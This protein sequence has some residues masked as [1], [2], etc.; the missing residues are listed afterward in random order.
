MT[1]EQREKLGSAG[2]EHVLNNYSPEQYAEQWEELFDRVVEK[3]GS[4]DTRK[5]YKAWELIEV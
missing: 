1:K 4:W 5:G 2:R 3:H